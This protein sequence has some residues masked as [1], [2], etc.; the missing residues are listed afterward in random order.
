MKKSIITLTVVLTMLAIAG[1]AWSDELNDTFNKVNRHLYGIG[2]GGNDSYQPKEPPRGR[3][4]TAR[5]RE[6]APRGREYTAR[7][8]EY[9]AAPRESTPGNW[10]YGGSKK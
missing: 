7:G 2:G 3:E 10:G 1:Y 8:R 5:P 6:E 9:T 4:Y